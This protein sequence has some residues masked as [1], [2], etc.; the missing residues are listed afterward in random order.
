MT[1]AVME[2]PLYGG[3]R[4]EKWKYKQFTLKAATKAY[5]GAACVIE[6]SSGQVKPAVSA[7]GLKTLGVFAETVDATSAGPLG[8]TAQ[9]VNVDLL[10]ERTILWRAQDGTIDSGDIG[11]TCYWSDDLTVSLNSTS[12]SAAGTILAVDGTSYAAFEIVGV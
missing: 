11:S 9:P 10:R 8:A 2:T 3:F 1:A 6:T 12:Q 5:K 4:D 7:S